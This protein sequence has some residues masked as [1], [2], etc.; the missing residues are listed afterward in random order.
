MDRYNF[1]II[2]KKWQEYW[3]ENQSFKSTIVKDKKNFMY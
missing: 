3:D 1:N 2:E